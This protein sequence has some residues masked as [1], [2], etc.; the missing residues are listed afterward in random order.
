LKRWPSVLDQLISFSFRV[1]L[2]TG[3]ELKNS[4]SFKVEG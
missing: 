2:P 1:F 4:N 3:L